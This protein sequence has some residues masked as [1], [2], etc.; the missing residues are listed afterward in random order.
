MAGLASIAAGV[1]ETVERDGAFPRLSGDQLTRLAELG[2]VREVEPG[3][4][5][6]AA[7]DESSD[8]FVVKSGAAAI[9]QGLGQENR[10]IAVQGSGRFLGELS[11]IIGQ[12]L[13]LTGIA[14]DRGEVIQV[15]L[16]RLREIVA[17][18]KTLSDLILGA[19][20]ARRS[21]LIDV[22]TGMKLIG[23]R[24]S[25]DS[26]RLRELLA[27]NRMPHQWIDLEEDEDADTLLSSLSIAIRRPSQ[28]P[29]AGRSSAIQAMPSSGGRSVWA[30]PARRLGSP[31]WWSSAPGRPGSPPPSTL[32]RK[33]IA[34][35]RQG[36]VA[37]AGG[38]GEHRDE[39][40][41]PAADQ[42]LAPRQPEVLDPHGRHHRD[43]VLDLLEGEDLLPLEP[44][45]PL[46]R[47][48]VLAA[49]VAAV[50]YG[51]AQ[52]G[53]PP[54]MPV[55]QGFP[56]GH[57]HRQHPPCRSLWQLPASSKVVALAQGR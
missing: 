5:L 19:F 25:P 51:D 44:R 52:I 53:D 8:F 29:G 48:A 10:G 40:W 1:P 14:I 3:E 32:R 55:V 2:R 9:V 18:D 7:G 38:P 56:R 57:S 12:R 28:S 36:E 4:V 13:Y 26:R 46:G 20:I 47:H 54:A 17:E 45:H 41:E 43:Q 33:P 34:V 27:R 30:R 11:L 37:V 39:A 31:T 16:E 21:I 24:F 42:R 15:S 50:G 6:F 35:G 49:E 23:S 22:G